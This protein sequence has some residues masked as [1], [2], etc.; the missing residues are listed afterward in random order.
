MC[1]RDGPPH[2]PTPRTSPPP[3]S[4]SFQLSPA[5]SKAKTCVR[6][7]ACPRGHQNPLWAWKRQ[8]RK[9]YV[10]ARPPPPMHCIANMRRKGGVFRLSASGSGGEAGRGCEQISSI[11]KPIL[12]TVTCSSCREGSTRSGYEK[13]ASN[14]LRSPNASWGP[15]WATSPG[16]ETSKQGRSKTVTSGG[17]I[18]RGPEACQSTASRTRYLVD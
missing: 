16:T 11:L 15:F 13:E 3:C 1:T 18:S 14:I 17:L 9:S 10:G 7:G 4:L 8:Y 5:S 12:R 2:P 6:R